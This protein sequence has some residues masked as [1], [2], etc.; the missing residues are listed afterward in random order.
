MQEGDLNRRCPIDGAQNEMR[1][2]LE[3]SDGGNSGRDIIVQTAIRTGEEAKF[4]AEI[5]D[6]RG[7]NGADD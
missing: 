7:E 6:V 4:F 1:F 3:G 2:R 5:Q